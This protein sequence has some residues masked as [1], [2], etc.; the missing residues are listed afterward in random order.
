MGLWPGDLKSEVKNYLILDLN[1][2]QT[3]G[4]LKS[5][6]LNKDVFANSILR[7]KL[8][9]DINRR[10]LDLFDKRIISLNTMPEASGLFKSFYV[11]HLCSDCFMTLINFFHG[12]PIVAS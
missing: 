5:I 6:N 1:K 2:T 11:N 7:Y 4:L 12:C 8:T 3:Q 10:S 9:H